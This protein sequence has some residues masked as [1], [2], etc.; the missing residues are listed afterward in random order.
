MSHKF[1]ELIQSSVVSLHSRTFYAGGTMRGRPKA[2]LVLT[3]AEREQ[4]QAWAR[5]RKTSQALAMRSRIVLE[6]ASGLENQ[7]V[8]QRLDTSAQTVSKWRNRFLKMRVDRIGRCTAP[9]CS[10]LDR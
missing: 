4:L 2:E 9:R 6:C 7:I 1:V 5:R 3:Q 8:A 10:A